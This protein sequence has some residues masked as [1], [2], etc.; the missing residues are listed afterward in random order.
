MFKKC[1][2]VCEKY[3]YEKYYDSF[4]TIWVQL[5]HFLMIAGHQLITIF[6]LAKAGSDL[7]SNKLTSSQ[8][9]L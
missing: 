3:Q 4:K 5:S 2:T 7:K 9:L 8:E 6:T 1:D